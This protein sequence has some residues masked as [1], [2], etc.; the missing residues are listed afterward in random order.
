MSSEQNFSRRRFLKA[1]TAFAAASLISPQ[2]IFGNAKQV[3][4][5]TTVA[6][7]IMQQFKCPQWF[8]DAK[9]GLWLHWGPQTIPSKGA[10]WY[11]HHMYLHPSDIKRNFGKDA[12]E[13]HRLTFG[14]QADFGYKDIC[15]LWKAEKFNAEETVQLFKK[16]GARY[17]AIIAAHHDNYDLF[18]SSIHGWNATKVGPKRDILGEFAKA[19]RRNNL[20]WAATSHSYQA[21][22]FFEGAFGADKSGPRKGEMYDGR[23]TKADGECEWWK[24]LDP[25][26]LYAVRYPDFDR[27][28]Q[29]RLMDLITDYQPDIL[30]FDNDEVPE[31]A[32][33]VCR[34]FYAESLRRNGSIQ[35]IVTVKKPQAGTILDFEK[36][37][38]DKIADEYWQTDTS[39]NEDWFLKPEGIDNQLHHN[40]RSLKELL[41]DI[42][43]KRGSLLLN[44]A[45]NADGSIPSDQF[46]ILEEFGEW[47]HANSEAIYETTPWKIYGE[48]G[49]STGG[50]FNERRVKSKAWDSDVR[51]FTCN[52]DN[53]T[54]YIHIFGNSAGRE[55]TID[56][57]A[58]KDLF[59][60]KVKKITLI[61]KGDASLQWSMKPQ[62]LSVQLPEK[63][64]FADCNILK[65]VTTGL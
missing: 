4:S 47:L 15:N 23:L 34:K 59:R 38:D 63:L 12:W 55:I 54:L 33:D 57:L 58:N 11:A 60:G 21:K 10:G 49:A 43:S 39:M 28:Y 26:Q 29:L 45:V 8:K 64:A 14:H 56:S 42:I 32:L 7:D 20:K 13:Y 41:V 19:A 27:E 24:G 1:G 37:V 9:F 5:Q 31:P 25:Q 3:T 22:W 50:H 16:W 2:A 18:N 53:K 17:V 65:V 30:Y 48:N 35:N 36:G 40:V 46:V 51:R 52:K 62:G 61:G 6:G 44:V